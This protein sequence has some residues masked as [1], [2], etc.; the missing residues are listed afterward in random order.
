M[1]V[2]KNNMWASHGLDR[3]CVRPYLKLGPE[4]QVTKMASVV[5]LII[6]KTMKKIFKKKIISD[7]PTQIFLRYE[8]GTTVHRYFFYASYKH[9]T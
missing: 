1:T 7:L 8:T 3:F 2:S 9:I 6:E 4:F 5:T